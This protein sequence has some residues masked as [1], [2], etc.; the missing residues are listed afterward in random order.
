M[1]LFGNTLTSS[2]IISILDGFVG[3]ANGVRNGDYDQYIDGDE[4]I[5][6]KQLC[7]HSLYL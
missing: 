3:I 7:S 6:I 2:E 5:Q 1:Q 4:N